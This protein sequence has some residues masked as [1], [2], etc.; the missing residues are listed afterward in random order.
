MKVMKKTKLGRRLVPCILAALMLCSC[1]QTSGS[2]SDTPRSPAPYT[3]GTAAE[4]EKLYAQCGSLSLYVDEKNAVFSVTDDR[5]NAWRSVPWQYEEDPIAKGDALKLL[6]SLIQIHYADRLGNVNVLSSRKESV[7]KG[8]AAVIPTEGGVRMEFTFEKYGITVPIEILLREDGV[9]VSVVTAD[10]WEADEN[11]RL[12]SV[13]VAPYFSAAAAEEEGYILVPDGAGALIKWENN[14]GTATDYSQYV[15][16]R[17]AAITQLEQWSITEDIRLPVFGIRHGGT[18]FTAI[19]TESASRA[20]LNASVAGKRNS[21]SNVY[22]EFI[23]RDHDL[24]LVEKKNQTVRIVETSHTAAE[25]QTVRYTLMTGED[26]SY[27]D[28]AAI[29]RDYLLEEANVTPGVQED[30]APLVIEL[31]GGVMTQQSVLGFPVDQVLAL[32]TFADAQT[33]LTALKDAGVDQILI[34]VTEWQ[35]D[36]TGA[37]IQTTV[38]PESRLGGKQGLNALLEQC[39]QENVSVFLTANTNRMVKSAWGYRKKSDSASSL[40]AD[41]VMQYPYSINTGEA[42]VSSPCFYLKPQKLPGT[43]QSLADS[44][45]KYGS[46]GL[47]TDFLG[48]ILYADFDK[49]AVTREQSEEIWV[50]TLEALRSANQ[51]LL[52]SG[53]N[54]YALSQATFIMDAPME[55]S[56]F[57]I[58]S[59]SVPFYQIALHGIVPIS[60]TSLNDQSDL[61]RG[62]LKAV[63][64][65]SCLK[66]CWIARNENE[67]VETDYNYIISSRYE[68]W[69]DDAVSQYLEAQALLRRVADCTVTR[70]EKLTDSGNVTRTVWS[71]GISVL[72]NYGSTE[73][74]VD[75]IR[76]PAES[77]AVTGEGA[78]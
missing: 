21:Y 65:G 35:K 2:G 55:S 29:Y 66:W 74:T 17:D 13:D 18:G 64:T 23:Y 7:E 4:G 62:F 53:G 25:R 70:H 20:K 33:I 26:S 32:T 28:M 27:V 44:A 76:I 19:L 40:R 50:Q 34:N 71:N 38:S 1:A 43:A 39:R 51:S 5:G 63:E 60:T 72:V 31:F 78:A 41:P 56:G 73:V 59:E 22:A 10:I 8:T 77:F 57:L 68:N 69:I 52:V 9:E 75:G 49:K 48:D 16:G 11:Y 67:L 58:E 36:G 54:A 3:V 47:A 46:V 12:L 15:Y 24:V 30:Y 42:D 45:K 37:A 61:R 14:L 6:G